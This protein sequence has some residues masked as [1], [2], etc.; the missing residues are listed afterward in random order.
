[1]TFTLAPGQSV[2]FSVAPIKADGT[3]STA[4]LSAVAF[5]SSDPSFTVAPDPANPNG[6][7]LTAVAAGSGTLTGTAVATE[8]DGTTTEKV[9]GVVTIVVAVPPP[10]P[11]AALAFTFGTPTP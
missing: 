8:P 2:S 5:T 1:M 3:P 6:G 11:A 10:A 4:T 9:Q 7:I